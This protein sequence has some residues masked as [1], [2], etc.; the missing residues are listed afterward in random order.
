MSE[1]DVIAKNATKAAQH[2]AKAAEAVV[3]PA[4]EVLVEVGK[5]KWITGRNLAI[6]A[7]LVVVTSGSV[8]AYK[9]IRA[10]KNAAQNDENPE[11]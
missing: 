3:E 4:K 11:V 2:A 10:L 1:T 8:Y 5:A 7:G 9:K 6:A